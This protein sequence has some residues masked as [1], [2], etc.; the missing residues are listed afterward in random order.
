MTKETTVKYFV[1]SLKTPQTD[2]ICVDFE[3][4]PQR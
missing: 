1:A 4:D 2:A 3:W